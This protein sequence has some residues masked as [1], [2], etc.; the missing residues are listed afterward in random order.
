M[1]TEGGEGAGGEV[2]V[3]LA[4]WG[5]G[6]VRA[7]VWATRAKVDTATSTGQNHQRGGLSQAQAP[8]QRVAGCF[9]K[10]RQGGVTAEGLAPRLQETQP[11]M[12]SSADSA[13]P[14]GAH[15]ATWSL[16]EPRFLE[17]SG[18]RTLAQVSAVA[19]HGAHL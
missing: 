8:G 16:P 1:K 5:V 10:S 18:N 9:G 17:S 12:R 19:E 7:A 2:Q 13:G 15:E 14:D 6:T 11:H 3:R 4:S